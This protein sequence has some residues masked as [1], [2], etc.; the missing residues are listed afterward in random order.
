MRNL[1]HKFGFTLLELLVVIGIIAVLLGL[2]IVSYSTAQMKARDAKRRSDLHAFQNAME[3]CYSINDFSYPTVTGDGTDSIS[4]TCPADSNT[5]S[6][7][8]P[9][10]GTV[11]SVTTSTSSYDITIPLETDSTPAEIK[12]Q[13]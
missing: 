1:Y 7:T 2:G 4:E 3:Q 12:S 8:S 9:T 10:S 13:Q 5:F 11:Y 6:I